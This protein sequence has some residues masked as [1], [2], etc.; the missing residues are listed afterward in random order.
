M[1]RSDELRKRLFGCAPEERLP[2]EAYSEEA[3]QRVNMTLVGQGRD[4]VAGGHA[5]IL[6]ATFLDTDLREKAAA[7]AQAAGVKFLGVW[8]HAPLVE[9]ERRIA[10]RTNDASDATLGVLR[11][12]AAAEVPPSDWLRLEALDIGAAAQ[13]VR[14]KLG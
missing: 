13:A 10:E 8:L 4:V 14:G 11:R 12:S 2:P 7:A 6:D 1:L 5:V 3:N 9:L